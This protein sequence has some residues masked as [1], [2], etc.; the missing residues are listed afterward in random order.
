VTD[1]YVLDLNLA[2]RTGV[3]DL[4]GLPL[5]LDCDHGCI[6]VDPYQ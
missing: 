1:P 5:P 3:L 4:C 2:P 6:Q